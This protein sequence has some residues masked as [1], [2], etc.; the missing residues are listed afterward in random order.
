MRGRVDLMINGS[1]Q[2]G[3]GFGAAL[4]VVLLDTNIFPADVGWRFA[5]GLGAI[6]G[7]GIPLVRRNVPESPGWLFVNG[8]KQEAEELV[9]TIEKG[10]R[11]NRVGRFPNRKRRSRLSP[12]KTIGSSRSRERCSRSTRSARCCAF[13]CL[14]ARLF[15]QRHLFHLRPGADNILWCSLGRRAALSDSVRDREFPRTRA[16]RITVRH[17]GKARNDLRILIL[18]GVLLT[19]TG[20]LFTEGALTPLTQT[21]A[22]MVVFFFASAGA[23]AAY[24][25]AS[26][27]FPIE[28]RAL[29]IAFFYA[30]GTG[31]RGIAGPAGLPWDR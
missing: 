10:S 13:R 3:T 31:V 1:Y 25:T 9:T 20:Y 12:R 28:M 22:W 30:I 17:G 24:L 27:I 11:R 18:S 7:L 21:A 23:S 4:S 14:P 26:E 2:V 6:L 29:A 19:I 8:R 16:A 15:I 5:F